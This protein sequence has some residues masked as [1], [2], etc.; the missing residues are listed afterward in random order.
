MTNKIHVWHL[1]IIN[2][3]RRKG[4]LMSV[5]IVVIIATAETNY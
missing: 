1:A 4:N 5:P 2:E 3:G